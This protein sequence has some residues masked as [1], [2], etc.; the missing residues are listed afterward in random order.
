MK[1]HRQILV[2]LFILNGY[3]GFSQI[4]QKYVGIEFGIDGLGAEPYALPYLRADLQPVSFQGLSAQVQSSAYQ[5]FCGAK[6]EIKSTNGRF[7]FLSGLQ[8]KSLHTALSKI[9]S[10]QYFYFQFSENES[11]TEYYRVKSL[12]QVSNYITMPLHVRYFLWDQGSL[13]FYASVGANLGYRIICKNQVNFQDPSMN[14]YKNDVTSRM[15]KPDPFYASG[16]LQGGI[17]I[18]KENKPHI[19]IGAN[20]P[21]F[22]MHQSSTLLKLSAGAGLNVQFLLPF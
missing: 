19:N 20:L 21:A 4:G 11:S 9:A 2:L 6:A 3:N 12:Q 10:P 8:I 15:G 18:G 16:F 13:R 7:G 17:D 22:F 14:Q 1:S 5:M